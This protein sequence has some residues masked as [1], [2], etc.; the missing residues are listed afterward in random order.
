MSPGPGPTDGRGRRLH[1]R[2]GALSKRL[3]PRP[4]SLGCPVARG[5]VG[6]QEGEEQRSRGWG[7]WEGQA[8]GVCAWL[9]EADVDFVRDRG[10]DQGMW[11]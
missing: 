11:A 9:A 5:P 10:R 4:W 7:Q 1:G 2:A 8:R 3:W 6:H